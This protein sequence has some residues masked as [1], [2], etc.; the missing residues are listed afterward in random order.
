[1]FLI[2]QEKIVDS[3]ISKITIM[4]KP[5]KKNKTCE[6]LYLLRWNK[7]YISFDAVS[8]KKLLFPE[9]LRIRAFE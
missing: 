4:M 7:A 9:E 8:L 6:E 3:K 2:I 1:M 5:R